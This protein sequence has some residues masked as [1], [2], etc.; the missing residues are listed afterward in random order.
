MAP[1]LQKNETAPKNLNETRIEKAAQ[2]AGVSYIVVHVCACTSP[3]VYYEL[4][5]F[6][7][8]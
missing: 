4:G 1:W 6:M 7:L 3:V 5:A 2:F 8:F